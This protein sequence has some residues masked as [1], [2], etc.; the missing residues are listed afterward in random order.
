MLGRLWSR[1]YLYRQR[2][3]GVVIAFPTAYLKRIDVW[4]FGV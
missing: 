4:A 2:E 3:I 1:L